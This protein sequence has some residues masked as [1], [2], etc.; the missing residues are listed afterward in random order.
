MTV[1]HGPESGDV[2]AGGDPTIVADGETTSPAIGQSTTAEETLYT[3]V[4]P[5]GTL[6]VGDLLRVYFVF[7]V[8]TISTGSVRFRMRVDG[9]AL[10]GFFSV[11]AA[12]FEA[13]E[14]TQLMVNIPN[15]GSLSAAR[16]IS[17][18]FTDVDIPGLDLTADTTW[19]FTGQPTASDA[20]TTYIGLGAHLSL[21]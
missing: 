1:F 7:E 15:G 21:V 2:V 10:D 5:G 11:S 16:L 13:F 17:G 14:F 18:S 9:T 12:G 8:L 4:I 20:G 3:L 19:T 6:K